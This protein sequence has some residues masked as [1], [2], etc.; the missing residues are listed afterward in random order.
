MVRLI[1]ESP[2]ADDQISARV[3][4]SLDHIRKLFLFVLPELVVL[5]DAGDI[6]LMLRLRAGWLKRASQD[7]E[8]G[9]FDPAR[10][11]R[12]GHVLVQEHTLDEGCIVKRT[13]DFAINFDQ[14][15]RDVF[16]LQISYL[17]YC[18]YGDLGEF[19][20]CFR[21]AVRMRSVSKADERKEGTGGHTF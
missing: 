11:L 4:D 15:E 18:V 1:V 2:L 7:G 14:V 13:T 8:F 9:I 19:F 6:E 16:A 3:L 10:H 12:V 5:L 21:Y 17:E 20:V